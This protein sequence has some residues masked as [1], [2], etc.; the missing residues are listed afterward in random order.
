MLQLNHVTVTRGEREVLSDC[1]FQFQEGKAYV[2][3]SEDS[4]DYKAFLKSACR[5]KATR[6]GEI[7]T[8]EGSVIYNGVDDMYLPRFLTIR[9][10]L[11]ELV[12]VSEHL[13]TVGAL[14]K[15]LKI[16]ENELGTTIGKLSE[17]TGAALRLAPVYATNPYVV[18]FGE[19]FPDDDLLC[20]FINEQKNDKVIIIATTDKKKAGR[21]ASV[22]DG[23]VL[24][25]ESGGFK[26]IV[27]GDM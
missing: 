8:W 14:I 27:N 15:R 24:S 6:R 12:E 16:E 21:I 20:M 25:M 19:P 17:S 5:E 26:T 2:I 13:T 7:I 3:V 1:T 11:K 4:D 9:E 10:Y 23:E 22:I 18:I